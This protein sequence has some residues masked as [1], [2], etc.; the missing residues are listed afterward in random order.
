MIEADCGLLDLVAD[1]EFILSGGSNHMHSTLVTK[2]Y[3]AMPEVAEDE[4]SLCVYAQFAF[5]FIHTTTK[6]VD[7]LEF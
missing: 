4:T 6:M 2:V 3:S 7:N 5:N 1:A